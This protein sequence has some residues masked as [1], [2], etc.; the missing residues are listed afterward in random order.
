MR[1]IG[2]RV[3]TMS[4]ERPNPPRKK[5]RRIG[6]PVIVGSETPTRLKIGAVRMPNCKRK[7]V[8]CGGRLFFFSI[9]RIA[10]GGEAV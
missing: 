7:G 10:N 8:Q 4:T 1:V 3:A 5:P 2:H 6:H 9:F